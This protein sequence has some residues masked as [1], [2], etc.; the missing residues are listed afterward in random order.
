MQI[1][2]TTLRHLLNM[3]DAQLAEVI[4]GISREAGIDPSALGLNPQQ[5]QSVRQALGSASEADL[6]Q[7]NEI[8]QRFLQG[9]KS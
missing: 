8:Y 3:N 5:I 7:L 1:D 9:K 2:Q 4:K 6:A